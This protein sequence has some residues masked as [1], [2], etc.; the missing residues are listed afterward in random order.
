MRLWVKLQLAILAVV[1]VGVVVVSLVANQ[2]AERE[3]RAFMFGSGMTTTSGL[4]QDLA[5]YYQS[6]GG[7]AN[8]QALLARDGGHGM[9]GGMGMSQRLTLVDAENRLIADSAGAP[10]GTTKVEGL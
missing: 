6:Q 4:A 5:E 9:M 2:A 3:V 1:V 7:W 8:V 10:V